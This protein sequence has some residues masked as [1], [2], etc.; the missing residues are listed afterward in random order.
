MKRDSS[1]VNEI[2]IAV[3]D[4]KLA[5]RSGR[6]KPPALYSLVVQLLV[7]RYYEV[8]SGANRTT[9]EFHSETG[10]WQ[11]REHRVFIERH[12]MIDGIRLSRIPDVLTT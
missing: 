12:E 3:L 4:Y 8:N 1:S 7:S 9:S 11:Q 2:E 10:N 5:G 6:F